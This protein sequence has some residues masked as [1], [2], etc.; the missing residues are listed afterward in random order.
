M[1]D[2]RK[3]HTGEPGNRG[4]FGSKA[5]GES[6]LGLS[7][8]TE[9]FDVTVT[10]K[11]NV[12][13]VPPGKRKPRPVEYIAKAVINVPSVTADEA[14]VGIESSDGTY[15][16]Y[17]ENLYIPYKPNSGQTE[18]SVAG[19]NHFPASVGS[20]SWRVHDSEAEF[21]QM[22][23]DKFSE[24]LV[25]DG[26]VWT[27]TTEPRYVVQTFGFGGNH[28]GTALL[29]TTYD[30]SNIAASSYFRA[31]EFEA[32]RSYAIEVAEERGDTVSA[33]GI[34]KQ[35]PEISV[36]DP[37]AIRLVTSEPE[38]AETKHAR[39]AFYTLAD[40]Y[41]DTRGGDAA[42]EQKAWDELVAARADLLDRSD[43]I[44][45]MQTAARP[46]EDR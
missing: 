41:G 3:K 33:A 46:F 45:G 30:N 23:E 38:P 9:T 21:V 15:R 16:V 37:S 24:F 39:Y 43:D 6:S 12:L 2:I 44:S 27:K 29:T 35:E 4:E 18:V 1:T 42:L 19:D 10:G 8:H 26:E 7:S 32:A 5:R 25:V 31:D 22:T 36:H 13:E 28:G 17:E 11:Y 40:R 34:R 14:P 20:T